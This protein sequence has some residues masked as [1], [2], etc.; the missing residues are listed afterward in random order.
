M[1]E[2]IGAARGAR[3][4]RDERYPVVRALLAVIEVLASYELARRAMRMAP[5][6]ILA[7]E[8]RGRTRRLAFFVGPLQRRIVPSRTTATP[9]IRARDLGPR[10]WYGPPP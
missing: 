1:L 4:R 3:G 9:R 2:R 10:P 6:R 5:A 8:W 7:L